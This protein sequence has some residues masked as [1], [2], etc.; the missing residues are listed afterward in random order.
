[1]R[2]VSL[3]GLAIRRYCY[4]IESPAGGSLYSVN[5]FS[6]SLQCLQSWISSFLPLLK[7]CLSLG[8]INDQPLIYSQIYMDYFFYEKDSFSSLTYHNQ[9]VGP[10]YSVQNGYELSQYRNV[11]HSCDIINIKI[12]CIKP[13]HLKNLVCR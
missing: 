6:H 8:K 2:S 5:R 4:M 7:I 1:M 3:P 10:Y 13:Q 11:A 9:P 12:T